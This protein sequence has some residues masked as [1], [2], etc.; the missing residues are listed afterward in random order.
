MSPAE[1][2]ESEPTSS[3]A[4]NLEMETAEQPLAPDL[5]APEVADKPEFPEPPARRGQ[6]FFLAATIILLLVLFLGIWPGWELLFPPE[7]KMP[8]LPGRPPRVVWQPD[9]RITLRIGL[10]EGIM[11]LWVFAFGAS[12]GSFLHVVLYRVPLGKSI[13]A[14]GSKCPRC[15]HAIRATDNLPVIGWLRLGG[16]CRDCGW[17]IPFRYPLAELLFGGMYLGLTLLELHLGAPNLPGYSAWPTRLADNIWPRDP[18][19]LLQLVYHLALA[20]WLLLGLLFAADGNRLPRGIFWVALA[21]GALAP[22]LWPGLHPVDWLGHVLQ[23]PPKREWSSAAATSLAGLVVG[24]L[25]A[26]R[27]LADNRSAASCGVGASL[28]LVSV[29]LGWQ[30][31]LVAGASAIAIDGL[32]MLAANRQ[33]DFPR[34]SLIAAV[35]GLLFL[36]WRGLISLP[37]FPTVPWSLAAG[38]LLAVCLL[39]RLKANETPGLIEPQVGG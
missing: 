19:P 23:S 21:V 34:F 11:C 7:V 16:K 24:G 4:R 13:V 8:S 22:L 20:H 5:A 18:F 14:G 39:P 17:P 30:M 6:L 37:G 15:G 12:M 28:W 35:I 10:T 25:V 2:P 26:W 33:R 38:V 9:P 31:G 32:L 29:Y 3:A 27:W 36:S 1:E